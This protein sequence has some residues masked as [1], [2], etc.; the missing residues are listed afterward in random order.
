ME[1]R[2]GALSESAFPDHGES[3]AKLS[4]IHNDSG[5]TFGV[6]TYLCAP[7]LCTR[8]WRRGKTTPLVT[9]PIAAV[10]KNH[11]IVTA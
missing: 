11:G 3:P 10:D 9:M 1:C 4:Q 6:G 2:F 8:G 7:K 5:V